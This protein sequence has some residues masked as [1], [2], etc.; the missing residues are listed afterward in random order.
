MC[1]CMYMYMYL[2]VNTSLI[3]IIQYT[4]I[5]YSCTPK[6]S[7]R[8]VIGKSLCDLSK[9]L[10]KDSA[11]TSTS[12]RFAKMGFGWGPKIAETRGSLFGSL[13]ESLCG[14]HG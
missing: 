10:E 11:S 7:G 13:G 4:P 3:I 9:N 1:K 8:Q 2:Y 5:T 6:S 12:V 14:S